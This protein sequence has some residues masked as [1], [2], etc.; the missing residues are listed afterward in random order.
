MTF[1]AS[2]WVTATGWFSTPPFNSYSGIRDGRVPFLDV[3]IR[4]RLV[5]QQHRRLAEQGPRR[6]S[7]SRAGSFLACTTAGRTLL[8]SSVDDRAPSGS[9]LMKSHRERR[10]RPQA[11]SSFPRGGGPLFVDGR[12]RGSFTQSATGTDERIGG[13]H[14][15]VL[16]SKRVAAAASRRAPPSGQ[17]QADRPAHAGERHP[18]P[19]EEAAWACLQS[20]DGPENNGGRS[21][22]GFKSEPA[23]QAAHVGASNAER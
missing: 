11:R 15:A 16:A 17:E 22:A 19:V 2:R 3:E 12:R 14:K 6:A 4:R 5:E 10:Q 13:R 8:P 20:P 9:A 21:R 7:A 23:H 18:A 1:S